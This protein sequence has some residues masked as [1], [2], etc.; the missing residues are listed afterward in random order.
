[1]TARRG[2]AGA[3]GLLIER[4]ADLNAVTREGWT[5][6]HVA[7]KSGQPAMVSLLIEAGADTLRR[8]EN[9]RAPK[10]V[11]RIRP[12]E[13]AVDPG[14]LEEYIGI[15]ETGPGLSFK[16]WREG[17]RLRIREFAPD[18]LYA[19]GRDEFFCRQEPWRVVFERDEAGSVSAVEVD[20]IRRKV[21]GEKTA[22]PLYVGSDV[23]RDCHLDG[24]EGNQYVAWLSSRHAAAYWRL[25]TDWALYLAKL[26]PHY[27]DLETPVDDDRC[28][29]CHTTAAQDPEALFA[30]GF[31]LEEGVGCETCHGPGSAYIDPDVMADRDAFLA[32]GGVVPSE[33]TCRRCHRK[34]RFHFEEWW[35]KIEHPRKTGDR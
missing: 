6:L 27:H 25:A 33:E 15:Y 31:R 2:C 26:R 23:C 21:R 24:G 34:D 29:L 30:A 35:P 28:L 16:I 13:T 5:P 8:D 18:E 20:F 32:A 17:D 14:A 12:A 10:D 11:K 1:V 22:H 7:Y 19:T 9:G 3:A 4:G